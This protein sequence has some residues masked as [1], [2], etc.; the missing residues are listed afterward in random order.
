MAAIP[1]RLD[2]A[3]AALASTPHVLRALLGSLP[4]AWVRATDGPHTWSPQQVVA[5][6]LD[7]ERVDWAVRAHTIL[8]HGEAAPFVP[9]D[10]DASLA[11][12]DRQP[13]AAL[14]D[15]FERARAENVAW[16][17]DAALS[18]DDLARTGTHPAFGGVTLR[19]LLATW[20]AHDRGH[21]V[22][23]ARTLARAY[24]D[25]VGPWAAYLSVMDAPRGRSE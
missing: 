21:I 10:R 25:E 5:H 15:A 20:V 8:A 6:L 17:R 23:I 19:Q 1:F 2:H 9:Y 24:R 12:A 22:Q 14:L 7:G 13:L 18:A 16:L 4:D 11:E 3:L